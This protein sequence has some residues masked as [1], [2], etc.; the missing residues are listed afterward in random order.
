MDKIYIAEHRVITRLAEKGPCVIVGRVA[1]F[2]LSD[3]ND[4]MNVFIY[5]DPEVRVQNVVKDLG[6]DPVK[7]KR[8]IRVIDNH[9]AMYYN[10]ISSKDWGARSNYHL[11]INSGTFGDDLCAEVIH[12]AA[13]NFEQTQ[14]E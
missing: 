12:Q 2:I 3:R 11:L 4:V 6:L 10:A 5:A 8:E 1:D 13:L 9:R 14:K 7:A